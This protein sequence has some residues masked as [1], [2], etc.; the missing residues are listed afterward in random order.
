M[1][2]QHL[3][4]WSF[5][6]WRAR[7]SYHHL[8]DGAVARNQTA[9]VTKFTGRL[10][11][12]QNHSGNH[13]LVSGV[14]GKGGK[15]RNGTEKGLD[16]SGHPWLSAWGWGEGGCFSERT[17]D[18]VSLVSHRE[19][20]SASYS[21]KNKKKRRDLCLLLPDTITASRIWKQTRAVAWHTV[22]AL[23][24]HRRGK[25]MYPK[26]PLLVTENPCVSAWVTVKVSLM[27]AHL[28][29]ISQPAKLPVPV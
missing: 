5:R 23:H 2:K 6:E 28:L 17:D 20:F 27:T 1:N 7:I 9:N 19:E 15:G 24:V 3:K 22:K 8:P 21:L 16:P 14:R 18:W 12:L 13:S 25:K 10:P 29:R 26:N 11:G 4:G